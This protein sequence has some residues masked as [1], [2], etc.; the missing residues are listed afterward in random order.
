MALIFQFMITSFNEMEDQCHVI[1]TYVALIALGLCNYGMNIQDLTN[2]YNKRI[3][4]DYHAENYRRSMIE[5]ETPYG[6]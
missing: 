2:L 3:R 5:D 6:F 1:I 4:Y